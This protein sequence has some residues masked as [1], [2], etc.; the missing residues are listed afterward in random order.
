LV[1]LVTRQLRA[2]L[3]DDV[4]AVLGE[5]PL[6]DSR[7]GELSWVDILS[8]V[9]HVYDRQGEGRTTYRVGGH[10]GAALPAVD[11]GWLLLTP[12]GFGFLDPAGVASSLLVVD[13]RP[14]LRFN[15][16]KCDPSGQALAGTMR[17]DET[18]GSGS[19]YRLEVGPIDRGK[20][21]PTPT[22]RVLLHD[23]GLSNGLGWS[24]G[25]DTLYFID[26]LTRS[27][28]SHS[29]SPDGE[30]GPPRVVVS[31]DA[32]L[33]LPDGMCVDH[34]GNL[35]VALYGGGAVHC[36]RPDGQLETVVS[37]PVSHPTSVTFGGPEGGRIFITTAGGSGTPEGTGAGGVWT[38]DPGVQGPPTTP[39]RGSVGQFEPADVHRVP[40]EHSRRGVT[41]E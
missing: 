36:Y 35:W 18:A 27:V 29:Y 15:D 34:D 5:G 31:L 40:V 38:I 39:W 6:W 12:D 25:G 9:V 1:A 33:G 16:A 32:S 4:G 26:T 28:V 10:V 13:P 23:V 37:L 21:G 22:A 3:F 20:G 17:Y 7:T 24:P 19:L 41:R 8:G 30:L 2:E 14:D 11:G